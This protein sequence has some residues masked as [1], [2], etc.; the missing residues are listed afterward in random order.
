GTAT[1]ASPTGP[2]TPSASPVIC[3]QWGSI[4]PR[5]FEGADG[6]VWL[7]WK[8]DTNAD[9]TQT[10]PTTIWSQQL[11]PDGLTLLGTPTQIAVATQP[12]ENALIESPDM[13]RDGSHY[14]LFFSGNQS[15]TPFNGV[16]V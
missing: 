6:R 4:D 16:G 2:F 15:V 1:A 5:T 13:V 10:I 3:Q 12:W 9:Q 8:S 7:I 14:Y 11:A